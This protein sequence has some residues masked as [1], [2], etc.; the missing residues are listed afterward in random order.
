MK[1]CIWKNLRTSEGQVGASKSGNPQSVQVLVGVAGRDQAF[2]ELKTV[3]G[4]GKCSRRAETGALQPLE[5]PSYRVDDAQ[6]NRGR[7]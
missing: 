6:E 5:S 2:T 1:K 4:D 7:D 3:S